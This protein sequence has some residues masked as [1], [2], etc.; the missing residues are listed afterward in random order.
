MENFFNTAFSAPVYATAPVDTIQRKPASAL[1][2]HNE[3]ILSGSLE[4][5]ASATATLFDQEVYLLIL[6][7]TR[8][9]GAVDRIPV[10]IPL[11][12][13]KRHDLSLQQGDLLVVS[14]QL[15]S[16]FGDGEYQHMHTV[17]YAS[18]AAPVLSDPAINSVRMTG[19]LVRV[20]VY[21]VT[22][23]GRELS[24]ANLCVPYSDP[25]SR[26]VAHVPVLFWG[27]SARRAQDYAKRELISVFGRIQSR[28][29]Q[30]IADDGSAQTLTTH[31][32][33]THHVTP[34][35]R[36]ILGKRPLF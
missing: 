23:F 29:Y 36:N 12:V 30:K 15:R 9:S 35:Q 16:V 14:G 34:V 20:P 25:S 3:V 32:V 21:N 31:E 22:P 8:L 28:E 4:S 27:M 26:G 10:C 24:T 13:A 5:G 7:S 2:E 18:I 33:S 6:R 19:E 1:F 17:V 11:A